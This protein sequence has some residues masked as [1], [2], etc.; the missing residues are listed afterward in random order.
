MSQASALPPWNQLCLQFMN[1]LQDMYQ[2]G[3]L[4][5]LTLELKSQKFSV[6]KVV[7]SAWSPLVHKLLGE[8]QGT[9]ETIRI[10][11]DNTE[12]FATFLAF[13]YSCHMEGVAEHNVIQML[14]LATSLQVSS[15]RQVCEEVLK[16]QL[17][18]SNIIS[19]FHLARRYR[20]PNLEEYAMAYLQMNLPEAVKQGDFLSLSPPRFNSFL[21]SGWVCVM[22]PEVKLFLIISWLGYDVKE[23]QQFLVL[24]LKYIDWSTVANDFLNEI[25]QTENFFTTNE[26][27]LYLL[28][29]T[30]FSSMIPLGPYVD[31]FPALREKYAYLLDHIVQ[32]S[33]VFPLEVDDFCPLTVH[34][35][36][37]PQHKSPPVSL[38]G[39]HGHGGETELQTQTQKEDSRADPTSV[40]LSDMHDLSND[41]VTAGIGLQMKQVAIAE[42]PAAPC[43]EDVMLSGHAVASREDR[44][45]YSSTTNPVEPQTRLPPDSPESLSLFRSAP[46]S[47]VLD[48]VSR[49]K[50]GPDTSEQKVTSEMKTTGRT[51]EG[52]VNG[53]EKPAKSSEDISAAKSILTKVRR[54]VSDKEPDRP[55]NSSSSSAQSN[56]RPKRQAAANFSVPEKLIPRKRKTKAILEEVTIAPVAQSL[57]ELELTHEGGW[58]SEGGRSV[59]DSDS[60]GDIDF[61]DLQ[62]DIKKDPDFSI[63]IKRNSVA[64]QRKHS[65][66]ING[67]KKVKQEKF[68]SKNSDT[69]LCDT[70]PYDTAPCDAAPCDSA[71]EHFTSVK[72]KSPLGVTLNTE[73]KPE[74]T[75]GQDAVAGKARKVKRVRKTTYLK[76]KCPQC[77][78]SA[79][80]QSRL[81]NHVERVH[82]SRAT[83][84]ACTLCP[85]ECMWSKS[86]FQHMQTH[87]AGP[88]YV[89]DIDGCR[90]QSERIHVLLIHRRRHLDERPYKCPQCS[91]KFRTRNNLIAHFKCHADHKNHECGVCGRRFKMKNTMQQHMV[92]HSDA[93][94]Y[95][96]D[97]CGFSTKFQ[98]H[99]ISHKRIHTG[100]VFTCNFINCTYSSPKRSQL[101]AHMRSHLNIRHHTCQVCHK[102]FVEKSHLVRHLKIHLD[103]RPHKCD[104]CDYSSTRIDKVN[105][106]KRK[107]HSQEAT[108]ATAKTKR[109][110]KYAPRGKNRPAQAQRKPGPLPSSL[111]TPNPLLVIPGRP[112]RPKK[113]PDSPLRP[114][115]MKPSIA[116]LVSAAEEL[117]L[118]DMIK[119]SHAGQHHGRSGED[120]VKSELD[121][122]GSIQ[123]AL[124]CGG[125]GVLVKDEDPEVSRLVMDLEEEDVAKGRKPG[126]VSK[127][128]RRERSPRKRAVRAG[129]GKGVRGQPKGAGVGVVLTGQQQTQGGSHPTATLLQRLAVSGVC[130]GASPLPLPPNA[131]LLPH[132]ATPGVLVTPP[133]AGPSR[134]QHSAAVVSAADSLASLSS[135]FGLPLETPSALPQLST[136]SQGLALASGHQQESVTRASGH[137][138]EESVTRGNKHQ[139][140]SANKAY[141]H[142]EL[143]ESTATVSGHQHQDL[144]N[145][146]RY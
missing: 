86:F 45:G 23:R 63:A 83:V 1:K 60:D 57:K 114:V 39:G 88:P 35:V 51:S 101:K 133:S 113:S 19:T 46:P 132:T 52:K 144:G 25:S 146:G 70:A 65:V 142:H 116:A 9:P 69:A 122:S 54:T 90:W 7:V 50:K 124:A 140:E 72:P 76:R 71:P 111:T 106:H 87:F 98:S 103:D 28:L 108:T 55:G 110:Y 135:G 6:H 94:P 59:S 127:E 34:L 130:Q 126:C 40:D 91:A 139:V 18:I 48:M 120:G 112:I 92:T 95:L 79:P 104:Q 131:V 74:I 12:V 141:Q 22:K 93:R 37:P 138:Q 29:Q 64:S 49:K 119:Q 115:L 102:A 24:L 129:S 84:Y 31:T 78:Y 80:T 36:A 42:P 11:Y 107:Y 61:K 97:I 16:G 134:Q 8:G 14:H 143:H 15:V 67:K 2:C 47:S 20:L 58:E 117:G 68:S 75:S 136:D 137:Q 105:E 4:C 21:S 30:L 145:S 56:R 27:S 33:F 118:V 82:G 73:V 77:D 121:G 41:S 81:E 32:N 10:Q 66:K 38:T 43:S 85:F 128:K 125:G 109:Q 53:L 62:E 3:H 89:C 100:E 5:D 13:L 123:L 99:L 96:C 17:K 44:H 26:S